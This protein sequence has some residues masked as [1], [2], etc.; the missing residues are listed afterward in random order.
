MLCHSGALFVN[1]SSLSV[2][3]YATLHV[4]KAHTCSCRCATIWSILPLASFLDLNSERTSHAPTS[5]SL[6][7]CT[8]EFLKVE[9]D[10]S[11]EMWRYLVVAAVVQLVEAGCV[12]ED[13]R[14][15]L[16]MTSRVRDSSFASSKWG[17]A[18]THLFSRC[19]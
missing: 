9:L 5:A 2:V 10:L 18:R 15:G 13:F 4:S 11:V 6:I 12:C 19:F 3:E 1:R 14:A 17:V 16:I 8:H 7:Y